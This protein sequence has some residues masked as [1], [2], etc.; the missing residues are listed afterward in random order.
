MK[1]YIRVSGSFVFDS[2]QGRRGEADM[3]TLVK[4]LVTSRTQ[5]FRSQKTIKVRPIMMSRKVT[6]LDRLFDRLARVPAIR[7][8][9][10]NL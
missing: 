10:T 7:K 2:L 3:F 9:R 6:E 1:T 8:S 5:V 4:K